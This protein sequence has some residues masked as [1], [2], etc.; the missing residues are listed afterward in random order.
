MSSASSISVFSKIPKTIWAIG[1]VSLLLNG[2]AVAIFTMYPIYITT[3]LGWSTASLGFFE[4]LVEAAGWLMRLLSGTISDMLR[5]RKVL[6]VIAYG[7]TAVSRLIFPLATS[8]LIMSIGR[9]VD[10]IGNGIQATPR[11]A[12]V[13]DMTPPEHKGAC[14]GMRTTLGLLGSCLGAGLLML[15]FR[16]VGTDYN[17]AFWWALIPTLLAILIL[18][19]FVQDRPQKPA[20]QE[21]TVETKKATAKISLND[22][23]MLPSGYWKVILVSFLFML[24]N[25]S[26]VFM[27]LQVKHA[28]L[29]ECDLPLV[30]ILQNL[31][32]FI[33]AFPAGYL[34]DRLGRRKLLA[35]GFLL[36]II[37]NMLLAST[38][39]MMLVLSGVVVWGLQMGINQSLLLAKVCDTAPD[40]LRGSAFGIYY[41]IV[42]FALFITNAVSGNLAK[43]FSNEYIFY[44]SSVMAGLA[45]I[46]LL[47]L[48]AEDKK[49]T[50]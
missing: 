37:S 23:L 6:L 30:M 8:G 24:S 27:I 26:G 32:A 28:G 36:V 2:S 49:Q 46:A 9:V 1:F 19:L 38:A 42:G 20:D 5:K 25:Y 13:G 3:V 48:P 35:G 45:M 43:Y 12:L 47:M 39:T 14:Y 18:V 11:D 22:I 50:A 34:S 21:N 29:Q 7:L 44:A 33:A 4:G 17:S 10:R 41:V 15:Y 31:S 16:T 40:E